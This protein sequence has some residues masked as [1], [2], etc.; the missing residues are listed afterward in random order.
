[1]AMALSIRSGTNDDLS[2]LAQ[3]N[4]RLIEDEG[5]RNPM[6]VAELERRMRGWLESGWLIDIFLEDGSVIGY[7]VYRRCTDDYHP[8]QTVVHLRQLFIERGHRNRGLGTLAFRDLVRTKFPR[9]STVVIDVL[10]S[11]PKGLTFW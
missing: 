8:D 7:A 5:S 4:K 6:S 2:L 1:M 9:R 11:N 3:M 10:A